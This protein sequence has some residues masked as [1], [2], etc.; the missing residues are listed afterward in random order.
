[1]NNVT[2]KMDTNYNFGDEE[3]NKVAYANLVLAVRET[4]AQLLIDLELSQVDWRL[5]CLCQCILKN[6]EAHFYAYEAHVLSDGGTRQEVW[7]KYY[8][9]HFARENAAVWRIGGFKNI[10][11]EDGEVWENTY[12]SF[13]T[14]LASITNK[15]GNFVYFA[16]TSAP[17][18]VKSM[19]N[20][21]RDISSTESNIV[22]LQNFR[23]R[24]K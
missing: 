20:Q 13:K 12:N 15:D 4:E 6:T 7:H 24:L 14:W 9:S 22:Y 17:I 21:Q 1:M 16:D 3:F 19:S 11:F 8:C 5:A 10:F 23:K 18:V 2:F